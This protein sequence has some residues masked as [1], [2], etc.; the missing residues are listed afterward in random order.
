MPDGISL[1]MLEA[2]HLLRQYRT[3]RANPAAACPKRK[4]VARSAQRLRMLRLKP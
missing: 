1:K 4:T 3:L 2:L